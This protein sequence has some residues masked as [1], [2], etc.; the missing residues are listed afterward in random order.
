MPHHSPSSRCCVLHQVAPRSPYDALTPISVRGNQAPVRGQLFPQATQ[1]MRGKLLAEP[2]PEQ[3]LPGEGS[4]TLFAVMKAAR[5]LGLKVSIQSA[6]R[7]CPDLVFSLR[8]Q[9]AGG[10]GGRVNICISWRWTTPFS[11]ILVRIFSCVTCKERRNR[12]A[13]TCFAPCPEA[14][15]GPEG[16]RAASGPDLGAQTPAAPALP[17][18]ARARRRWW[19]RLTA[20]TP[21][22][23]AFQRP[24][25]RPRKHGHEARGAYDNASRPARRRC[26]LAIRTPEPCSDHNT[27]IGDMDRRTRPADNLAQVRLS[28]VHSEPARRILRAAIQGRSP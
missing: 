24:R 21:I 20:T 11:S 3:V 4:P 10:F 1:N 12:H 18:N 22:R 28:L 5:A 26:A 15:H 2:R 16:G 8:V 23:T 14:P 27:F 13:G 9:P 7:S 25:L 17:P 19:P 6:A